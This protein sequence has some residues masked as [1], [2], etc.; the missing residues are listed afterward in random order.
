MA[1]HLALLLSACKQQAI[2]CVDG[3]GGERIITAKSDG[4][5]VPGQVVGI[6]TTGVIA[7]TDD[8]GTS[9]T[10]HGILLPKY[11][12]DCDAVITSGDMCEIVIPTAG[13]RYN[14]AT[15]DPGGDK[16]SGIGWIFGSTIGNLQISGEDIALGSPCYSSID[17]ANTSRFMEVVWGFHGNAQT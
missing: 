6:L 2:V 12:T 15:V 7:G 5:A 3:R 8:G 11:N 4:V 10:F 14:V 16:T 13:H 9:E 1:G 17:V